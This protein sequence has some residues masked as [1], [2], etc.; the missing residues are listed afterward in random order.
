MGL[1][2]LGV[3]P[4]KIQNGVTQAKLG[5]ATRTVRV[6]IRLTQVPNIIAMTIVFSIGYDTA[7]MEPVGNAKDLKVTE[8]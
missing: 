1:S 4:T 2:K 5:D 3:V 6:E 8:L 7:A